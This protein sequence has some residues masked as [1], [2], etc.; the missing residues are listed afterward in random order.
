[1]RLGRGRLRLKR[2]GCVVARVRV[3]QS[4]WR[5]FA[6]ALKADVDEVTETYAGLM[7]ASAAGRVRFI[8]GLLRGS[9]AV[10]DSSLGAYRAQRRIIVGQHYGL[11]VEKGTDAHVI[12]AKRAKALRFGDGR[13]A[14]R[15][16]HPG[17]RPYPF[18]EPAVRQYA[19]DYLAAV[20][21]A[22]AKHGR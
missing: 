21:V 12:E 4:R 15:V 7:E 1:M 11:F 16:N 14:K 10:V 17:S 9:I 6:E 20:A 3:T 22:V 2:L 5:E 8:T 18:L 19:D 13:F